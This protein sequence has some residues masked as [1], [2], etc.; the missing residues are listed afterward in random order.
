MIFKTSI[1]YYPGDPPGGDTGVEQDEDN[2]CSPGY[3]PILE[4]AAH[5]TRYPEGDSGPV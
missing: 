4:F 2:G 1:L 5:S 3:G